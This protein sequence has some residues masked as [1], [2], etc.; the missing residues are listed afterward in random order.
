MVI[1]FSSALRR[2]AALAI[3]FGLILPISKRSSAGIL[4]SRNQVASED[5]EAVEY[6]V[7]DHL[8]PVNFRS[9]PLSVRR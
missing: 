3:G 5:A 8:A 6:P 7:E 4:P 1:D 2:V 9:I